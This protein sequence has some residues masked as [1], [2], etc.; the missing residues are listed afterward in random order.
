LK[1][2]KRE[3]MS[4]SR[5]G[6]D[7]TRFCLLVDIALSPQTIMNST[8]EDLANQKFDDF[9][10]C[11]RF[12]QA[13]VASTQYEKPVNIYNSKS[14]INFTTLI[15]KLIKWKTPEE[16]SISYL[17]KYHKKIEQFSSEWESNFVSFDQSTLS[18]YLHYIFYKFSEIRTK[19]ANY[20]SNLGLV[21]TGSYIEKNIDLL[22]GTERYFIS[23]PLYCSTELDLVSTFLKEQ[24]QFQWV[25][26]RVVSNEIYKSIFLGQ[27]DLTD[28][29]P[30]KMPENLQNAL[31]S[32]FSNIHSIEIKL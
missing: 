31:V 16:L 19:N 28:K 12:I 4:Y 1:L 22:L 14:T 32:H 10:P 21:H 26:S 11:N 6:E 3:K 23:S 18:H 15:C 30:F 17:E 24:K 13:C 5:F 8:I 9:Y 27:N 2:A 20:I 7:L 29:V 25:V